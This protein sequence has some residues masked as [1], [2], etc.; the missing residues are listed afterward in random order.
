MHGINHHAVQHY[1][2]AGVVCTTWALGQSRAHTCSMPDANA[3]CVAVLVASALVSAHQHTRALV[4]AT[5]NNT[6]GV[7]CCEGWSSCQRTQHFVL[8]TVLWHTL[9]L[10]QGCRPQALQ[11]Y[12]LLHV[13]ALIDPTKSIPAATTPMPCVQDFDFDVDFDH[14]RCNCRGRPRWRHQRPGAGPGGA[15]SAHRAAHPSR[16]A[17]PGHVRRAGLVGQLGG[18][19]AA[20]GARGVRSWRVCVQLG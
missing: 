1:C 12:L 3:V 8:S 9:L 19:Q 13:G 5:H 18:H 7:T 16:P 6:L 15:A 20:L 11:T 17:A 10:Y 2:T 4:K 14:L